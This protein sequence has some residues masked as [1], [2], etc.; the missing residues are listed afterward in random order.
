MSWTYSAKCHQLCILYQ[1]YYTRVLSE[2]M[3]C[4][5]KSGLLV[6]QVEVWNVRE[7]WSIGVLIESM[8]CG[9][10]WSIGVLSESMECERRVV[11]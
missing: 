9:E 4:G 3:E 1:I 6:S 2:S 11:Y 5:E 7:E 10:E 8:E